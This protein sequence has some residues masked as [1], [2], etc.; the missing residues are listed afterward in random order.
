MP[1][2]ISLFS[3]YQCFFKGF[4]IFFLQRALLQNLEFRPFTAWFINCQRGTDQCSVWL[5][6]I[7]PSEWKLFFSLSFYLYTHFFVCTFSVFF[8]QPFYFFRP[9]AT[10]FYHYFQL[11]PSFHSYRQYTNTH[12]PTGSTLR[13]VCMLPQFLSNRANRQTALWREER[14]LHMDFDTLHA[15]IQI[16]TF[17]QRKQ[18]LP[19]SSPSSNCPLREESYATA[20]CKRLD[21][22]RHF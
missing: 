11:S 22:V 12:L 8:L 21:R 15:V 9:L 6:S 2:H 19:L 20:F 13:N 5:P 7:L 14:K 3:L 10:I 17:F 18:A 16:Q 4:F 1:L